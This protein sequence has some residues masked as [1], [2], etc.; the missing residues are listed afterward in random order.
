MPPRK[1]P[2]AL[3]TL[4][5]ACIKAAAIISAL[6]AARIIIILTGEAIDMDNPPQIKVSARDTG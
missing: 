5:A 4:K 3:A 6:G 2:S 1:A